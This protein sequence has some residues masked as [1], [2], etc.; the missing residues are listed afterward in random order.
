MM[1]SADVL[2]AAVVKAYLLTCSQIQLSG[3]SFLITGAVE[4]DCPEG[5]GG[6]GPGMPGRGAAA[7][8][9][10]GRGPPKPPPAPFKAIGW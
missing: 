9:T 10:I 3:N 1:M 2:K 5:D 8:T 6:G 7:Y 4:G